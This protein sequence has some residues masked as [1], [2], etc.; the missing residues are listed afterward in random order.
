MTQPWGA[1]GMH[2]VPIR[3]QGEVCLRVFPHIHLECRLVAPP[4]CVQEGRVN[5]SQVRPKSVECR[6]TLT[7]NDE[8]RQVSGQVSANVEA[9]TRGFAGVRTALTRRKAGVRVPQRPQRSCVA[10]VRQVDASGVL[11]AR[12][13]RSES[14]NNSVVPSQRGSARHNEWVSQTTDIFPE[15]R[16]AK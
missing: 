9:V 6:K 7:T 8:R 16:S 15:S 11:S 12:A 3:P 14:R 5:A 1:W 13:A 2:G 10:T 4:L